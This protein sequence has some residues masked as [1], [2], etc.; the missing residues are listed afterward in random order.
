MSEC[1]SSAKKVLVERVG[2]KCG[3][4]LKTKNL[5]QNQ[6]KCK[7]IAILLL[8]D[9]SSGQKWGLVG[10]LGIWD[11]ISAMNAKTTFVLVYVLCDT[12]SLLV[13]F[14]PTCWDCTEQRLLQN[15]NTYKKTN[16][17]SGCLYWNWIQAVQV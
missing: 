6:T 1:S 17:A 16:K 12:R 4:L 2:G 7:I 8:S 15:T 14:G 5:L 3:A 10:R 9:M 11:E 13:S